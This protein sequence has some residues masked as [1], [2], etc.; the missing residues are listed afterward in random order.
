MGL[1]LEAGFYFLWVQELK[2]GKFGSFSVELL[3]SFSSDRRF[4]SHACA[5]LAHIT[6]KE[7]AFVPLWETLSVHVAV[8]FYISL[9]IYRYSRPA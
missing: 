6:H 3:T 4:G 2:S 9:N 7:I 5:K 1:F 8:N